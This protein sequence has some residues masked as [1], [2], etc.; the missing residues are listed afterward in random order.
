MD[1]IER[2]YGD[3]L[4]VE[5][6]NLRDY[7]GQQA[8]RELH[9]RGVPLTVLYDTAGREVYRAERKLPRPR[10]VREALARMGVRPA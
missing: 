10:E 9:A 4:R 6:L 2:E 7:V 8:Y 5:R 1:G 3:A